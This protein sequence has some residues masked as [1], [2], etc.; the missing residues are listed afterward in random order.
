MRGSLEDLTCCGRGRGEGAR[1][2]RG[3][4]VALQQGPQGR[5]AM[6]AHVAASA[7]RHQQPP[8][9]PIPYTP[10]RPS[11]ACA[12]LHAVGGNL[13]RVALG[14]RVLRQHGAVAVGDKGVDDSHGGCRRAAA[15]WG[16]VCVA[17]AWVRGGVGARRGAR[18]ARRRGGAR[19]GA[20]RGA[21]RRRRAAARPRIAP[22]SQRAPA[23]GCC[24]RGAGP[25]T[26]PGVRSS[27]GGLVRGG[28][29]P[30][31]AQTRP[32]GTNGCSLPLR[33]PCCAA[34]RPSAGGQG[35]RA[36]WASR[37]GLGASDRGVRAGEWRGARGASGS[38]RPR[39]AAL[40]RAGRAASAHPPPRRR[41]AERAALRAACGRSLPRPGAPGAHAARRGTARVPGGGALRRPAPAGMMCETARLSP[42]P[43][44][45]GPA[46][47]EVY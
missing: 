13:R 42:H 12:H 6:R 45:R 38:S 35:D 25:S 40:R 46:H 5:G 2:S 24:R 41:R 17:A 47:A 9:L 39:G 36:G 26:W 32:W 11:H 34:G 31:P 44:T 33:P 23:P 19:R 10:A 20:R 4:A 21:V 37:R 18:S 16:G 1:Q 15:G 14:R 22:K 28:P 43:L 29:V 7:A 3:A 8:A 30:G 27:R